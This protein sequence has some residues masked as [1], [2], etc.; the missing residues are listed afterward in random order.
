[1]YLEQAFTTQL[2]RAMRELDISSMRQQGL[3]P[4]NVVHLRLKHLQNLSKMTGGWL[5]FYSYTSAISIQPEINISRVEVDFPKVL[6]IVFGAEAPDVA[7]MPAHSV[8]R[9][10]F[11]N[12]T[13]VTE[14]F[15]YL[16]VSYCVENTLSYHALG[17]RSS[18]FVLLIIFYWDPR[19]AQRN[20]I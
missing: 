6:S 14:A 7:L 3:N 12:H 16:E 2:E 17:T 20:Y 8:R 9:D 10:S 4:A 19:S 11:L 1:M 13:I 18:Y 5:E 15:K